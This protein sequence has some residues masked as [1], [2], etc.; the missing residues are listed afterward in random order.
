[1]PGVREVRAPLASGTLLLVSAYLLLYDSADAVFAGDRVSPGLRSVYDA[2]GKTGLLIAGA[3][4]AYVVGTVVT[5]LVVRRLRLFHTAAVARVADPAYLDARRKPRLLALC[6]PFSR[7]ALRRVRHLCGQRSV[8]FETVL[9]EIVLSGGKRLL[10]TN[11]DLYGDYDRFLSEAEFR[12]G[13]SAPS[14]LLAVAV[15]LQVPAAWSVEVAAVGLTVL[16]AGVLVSD[17]LAALR[18]AYSMYAH[19]VTDGLLSTPTLDAGPGAP[20]PTNPDEE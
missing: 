1:M 7:P 14:V 16:V 13:V 20:A 4:G 9:A 11:R 17:A 18:Q 5:G 2:L 10:G 19:L 15:A 3:I 8:P 12:L 6:S